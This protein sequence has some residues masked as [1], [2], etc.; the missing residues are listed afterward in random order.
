MEHNDKVNTVIT[1]GRQFGAGGR[2]LGRKLALAL[3]Y[4]YY[5]KE[6]LAEA[7]RQAGIGE[8]FFERNDER[9]PSLL[10]RGFIPFTF[11]MSAYSFYA[12]DSTISADNLRRAQC[13]FIASLPQAGPC[14]IVGRSADYILRD[15]PCLV[16]VFLSAP[17][18]SRVRRIISRQPGISEGKARQLAEKTDRLRS[19]YYNF[20]TDGAWGV[21]S[22]YH[23]CFDTSRLSTDDIVALIVE[24]VN[25]RFGLKERS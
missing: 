5:D 25:R 2:E 4:D 8:E 24:Y 14:V 22:T 18:E 7:S 20:Y 6:L 10:S 15:H 9:L 19:S 13:D 21:A 23:L 11:G 17:M 3:G 16:S 1:I 12:G